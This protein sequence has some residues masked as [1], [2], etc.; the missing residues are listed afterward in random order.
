MT[1]LLF[2]KKKPVLVPGYLDMNQILI[3]SLLYNI[4]DDGQENVFDTQEMKGHISIIE[5]PFME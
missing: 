2:C 5:N 1:I 4:S 3:F